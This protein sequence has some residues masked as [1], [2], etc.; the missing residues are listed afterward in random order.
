MELIR[1]VDE[2]QKA[3][4]YRLVR[5][6]L[7][8]S[9][10]GSVIFGVMAI[11]LGIS[12]MEDN[13]INLILVLIGV[14]LF[15]EGI[16]IIAAPTP[17]GMIADGIALILVGFWN[18]GITIAGGEGGFFT[19]LG[20]FQIGWGIQSF[21][22]YSRFSGALM[23]KP[24]VEILTWLDGI[25]KSTAK[26]RAKNTDDIIE[27]SGD[28]KMW[29]GMLM[30]NGAVFADMQQSDVIFV[31]KEEVNIFTQDR[32]ITKKKLK[33]S[34]KIGLR[35]MKGKIASESFERFETW[36]AS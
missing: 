31:S 27:F 29:K 30:D 16:W 24:S 34:F 23:E 32:D 7:R 12:F 15:I 26:A 14:F 10:I 20:I 28:G 33:A 35:E 6:Q 3:S 8:S 22:R 36:R 17:T 5:N 11:A 4:D 21:R 9:G 2:L 13:P 19:V 25:I 1:G 18:I